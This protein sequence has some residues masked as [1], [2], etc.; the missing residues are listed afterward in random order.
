[1]KCGT[2]TAAKGESGGGGVETEEVQT[3]PLPLVH[4]ND[5]ENPALSGCLVSVEALVSSTSIA[6][7]APKE[8]EAT[9]FVK[10]EQRTATVTVPPD[11][12]VNLKL[13]CVSED[14]KTRRM[15]QLFSGVAKDAQ[16]RELGFRTIYRVRV[17]PPVFTLEMRDDRIVDEAGREYKAYDVFVSSE[18]TISFQ[19]STLLR[20]TGIPLPNP[21]TQ[22]TT[23]LVTEVEFRDEVHGFD[24]E[25]VNELRLLFKDMSIHDR[26]TWIVDN[27]EG[28]SGIVG[29][30]NLALASLLTYFSPVRL[31]LWCDEQR[32]WV[33]LLMIGD[34]T[35]AK[36]E[37]LRKLIRL[38][39]AGMLVTAETASAVGLTGTAT[40]I[41]GRGW[42]VDWGFLVLCDRRLLGVDGAHKLQSKE[43]AAMAE[44]ERLGVV[45]IAKAAKDSAYARTRQIRI[46][47]AVDRAADKFTTRTMRSFLYPVQ[48]LD[49]IMDKTSIA[50]LDLAV[51]A[52]ERD[53]EAK[54]INRPVTGDYDQRLELLAEAVKWAWSTDG[55]IRFTPEAEEL[56]RTEATRLYKAYFSEV[57]PLV[58]I[59]M[60]WK[61]AR[62]SA[63]L[64]RATLSTEDLKGVTVEADHV[65]EVVAILEKE[66]TRAG[67]NT[68]AQ[69]TRYERLTE[70]EAKVLIA[71]VAFKGGLDVD[72]AVRVIEFIVLQGRVTADQLRTQ[73]SLSEKN[74]LRPLL[75]CMVNEGL[76]LR[77]NGFYPKPPMIELYKL[78]PGI[79]LLP[80]SK[81]KGGKN[82][83]EDAENMDPL[84]LPPGKVAIPGNMKVVLDKAVELARDRI[85]SKTEV[86]EALKDR[87]PAEEVYKRL[88]KLEEEGILLRHGVD[89]YMVVKP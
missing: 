75:A 16:L 68:L 72:A 41:E 65:R 89:G 52:D 74:Q 32:G 31:R 42:F 19:A 22:Q 43:W 7:L 3:P 45:I 71:S 56:L 67:L 27:F 81:S 8:I 20:L 77:G 66:Y 76:L 35:T 36:S 79:A 11:S 73:F 83:E 58:S 15:R 18:K 23:L 9:Y 24:A 14:V 82:P 2:S 10:D 57:I 80:G 70:E 61:L 37:T 78:L 86:V 6:Y 34:T 12:P 88:Y 39:R 51:F 17:R 21:A 1:M 60:K 30:R 28:Y 46:A 47:N 64:A 13:I 38:L 40:Q 26:V 55:V 63:A 44:S 29:R 50:R 4:L 54:D 49:T 25:K 59:D 48:A 33:L 84:D 5:I 87:I 53:V 62:L 69:A 85:G